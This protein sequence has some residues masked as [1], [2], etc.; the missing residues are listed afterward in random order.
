MFYPVDSVGGVESR[1]QQK[2]GLGSKSSS[3]MSNSPSERKP[4]AMSEGERDFGRFP[5]LASNAPSDLTSIS[6]GSGLGIST[7]SQYTLLEPILP[8]LTRYRSLNDH[9]RVWF[10][11]YRERT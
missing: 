2:S 5:P 4:S 11:L 1:A 9:P 7:G 8:I 10:R 6:S 3:V